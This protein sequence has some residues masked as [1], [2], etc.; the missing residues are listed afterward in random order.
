MI[1]LTHKNFSGLNQ[2]PSKH[3]TGIIDAKYLVFCTT[4][5]QGRIGDQDHH[6]SMNHGISPPNEFSTAINSFLRNST[7]L[8]HLEQHCSTSSHS[9]M[10]KACK[11]L[12]PLSTLTF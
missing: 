2:F 12:I 11:P 3:S 5:P 10:N 8:K 7:C 1:R 6:H 4:T 9:V